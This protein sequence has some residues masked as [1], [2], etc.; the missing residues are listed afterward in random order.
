M[1]TLEAKGDPLDPIQWQIGTTLLE[2][3]PKWEALCDESI[4]TA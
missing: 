1:D 3:D 4:I 2:V